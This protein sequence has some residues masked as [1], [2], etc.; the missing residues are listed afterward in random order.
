MQN[1]SRISNKET[2]LTSKVN[3]SS[4]QHLL[5]DQRDIQLLQ[6]TQIKTDQAFKMLFLG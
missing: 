3:V 2:L 6:E 4:H 1:T 5:S